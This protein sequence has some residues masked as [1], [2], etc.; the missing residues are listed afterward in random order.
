MLRGVLLSLLLAITAG[1]HIRSEE[2]RQPRA[3][4]SATKAAA[5]THDF[6]EPGWKSDYSQTEGAVV[7]EA[8]QHQHHRGPLRGT[9][10]DGDREAESNMVFACVLAGLGSVFG[11]G[12]AAEFLQELQKASLDRQLQGFGEC[13]HLFLFP[14]LIALGWVYFNAFMAVQ[15]SSHKNWVCDSLV[16][17]CLLTPWITAASVAGQVLWLKGV[18]NQSKAAGAMGRMM[19]I[20]HSP[21]GIVSHVIG[22][23]QEE[24]DQQYEHSKRFLVKRWVRLLLMFG[25]IL[26]TVYGVYLLS[27][28]DAASCPLGIWWSAMALTTCTGVMLSVLIVTMVTVMLISRLLDDCV[29]VKQEWEFVI[30]ALFVDQ[31]E[32]ME[33]AV[34]SGLKL[35]SGTKDRPVPVQ[36]VT[37]SGGK[38]TAG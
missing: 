1:A 18:A 26:S 27:L 9:T 4:A 3:P 22:D 35:P 29:S 28:P 33:E 16:W 13:A 21:W 11:L 38:Y 23:L 2:L 34:K 20:S 17:Y 25:Q 12:L 8:V 31:D 10:T 24:F 6:F 36:V 7:R 37:T 14:W 5:A 19:G 30:D 32:Q 15:G